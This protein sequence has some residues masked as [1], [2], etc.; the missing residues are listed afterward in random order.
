M[1]FLALV[2]LERTVGFLPLFLVIILFLKEVNQDV[3]GAMKGLGVEEINSVVGGGQM[4][5]HAVGHKTLL[6]VH[7]GGGLPGVV[8]K[9]DLM[10][11]SAK[12]GCRGAH[13]GVVGQAE[14]RKGNDNAYDNEDGG[15]N[16]LFHDCV[17]VAGY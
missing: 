1:A 15:F 17:P 2:V 6:I 5:V 9:L 13:H 4:A 7:M 14:K 16:K 11:G 10:A 8:G 12:L 3:F